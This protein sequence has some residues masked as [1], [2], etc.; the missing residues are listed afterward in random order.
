MTPAFL[1]SRRQ[2]RSTFNMDDPF[3]QTNIAGWGSQEIPMG[4]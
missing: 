1:A 3:P 4:S 2:A